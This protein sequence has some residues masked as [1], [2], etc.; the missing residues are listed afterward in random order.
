MIKVK[1]LASNNYIHVVA[2]IIWMPDN[3]NRFLISERQ[4]GK[5]LQG[6]WELPGGKLETGESRLHALHRE[7]IEEINIVPV[8]IS[9][10]MQI[11][12]QYED[13]NILLDV[14][15]VFSFEGQLRALEDQKIKWVAGEQ[16]D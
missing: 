8:E 4:K 1:S 7:L 15:Q 13:R 6:Y 11:G 9:E 2:A 10:F 5:H 14:W 12:H 3:S 16:R